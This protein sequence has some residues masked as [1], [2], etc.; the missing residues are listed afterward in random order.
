MR[1]APL[2]ILLALA[3]PAL[4]AHAQ[5]EVDPDEMVYAG[6]LTGGPT[7]SPQESFIRCLD[8]GAAWIRR[9]PRAREIESSC[10]TTE[11]GELEHAGDRRWFWTRYRWT[12]QLPAEGPGQPGPPVEEEEIVLFSAPL[13]RDERTAEW[14]ARY[15]LHWLRT[16]RVELAPTE[17]GGALLGVLACWDGTGGCWQMFMQRDARGWRP[18]HDRWL[19]QLPDSL[20]GRFWKGTF[21]N[22]M[23]MQGSASLYS[24][25]DGNCCPSRI[26]YFRVRLEGDALVLRDY[27]AVAAPN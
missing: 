24:P 6:V 10:E 25:G 23:T 4:P 7:L 1:T 12:T 22:P 5:D 17:A 21:I 13:D 3:S 26:L 27:R 11:I 20:Q 8:F 15:W 14:H 18:V 19:E 16:V 2:A 9:H